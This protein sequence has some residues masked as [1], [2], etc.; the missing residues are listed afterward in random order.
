L[1]A[2]AAD[3]GVSNGNGRPFALVVGD[4]VSDIPCAA[5][6]ERACAPAHA[7]G[8]LQKAGFDKMAL[9]YQAGL[10]EAATTLLGHPPGA[11]PVCRPPPLT[12]EQRVLMAMLA[13][14]ERGRWSMV[15]QAA[16]LASGGR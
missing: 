8:A 15:A 1:R 3:L 5:L 16:K 2:L 10:A 13:A 7:Q 14:Q 4:T 12:R 11:C 6:A 9:P